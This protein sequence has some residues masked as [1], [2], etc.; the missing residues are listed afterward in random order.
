M[1]ALL[2]HLTRHRFTRFLLLGGTAALVNLLIMYFLVDACDWKEPFWKNLANAVSM[3]VS[4][5]YSF[6]V[7]RIYVWGNQTGHFRKGLATQMWRYH[8]TAGAINLMRFFAIFPLL[9]WL[10]VHHLTNTVIGI[11]AGCVINY[12]IS[13]HFVFTTDLQRTSANDS[14][15]LIET[16]FSNSY[17]GSS[18]MSP[19]P[20]QSG[21]LVGP[22][23]YRDPFEST[24][25]R[26]I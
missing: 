9:D 7:Y 13:N 4:L 12:F 19:R 11:S 10:G 6:I 2:T 23:I 3:E 8:G 25:K 15:K 1:I 26:P 22:M 21:M 14:I 5:L 20:A 18:T 17:Q 16:C 24:N